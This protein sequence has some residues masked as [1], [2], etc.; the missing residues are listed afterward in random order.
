MNG[1]HTAAVSAASVKAK[2]TWVRDQWDV[3]AKGFKKIPNVKT[4][5]D[6][7]LKKTPQQAVTR[8]AALALFARRLRRWLGTARVAMDGRS[9]GAGGMCGIAHRA[10]AARV[11]PTV[12]KVEQRA[13]GDGVIDRLVCIAFRM[14]SFDVLRLNGVRFIIYLSNKPHQGLFRFRQHGGFE[15]GK[16]ARNEFFAAEQFRRDRGVRLRS[17]RTLIQMGSIGR[18]QLPKTGR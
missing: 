2:E 8:T 16:D 12:V 4:T 7:K 1:E 5:T 18:D 14:Q 9:L 15:I 6:A 13:N 10:H 11:D 3:P 17:K